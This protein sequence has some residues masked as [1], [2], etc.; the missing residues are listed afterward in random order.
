MDDIFIYQPDENNQDLAQLNN[1]DFIN[2]DNPNSGERLSAIFILIISLILIG[3]DFLSLYYS[4]QYIITSSKRYSFL[5]FERCIKY[6]SITEMYFTLFALLAAVSAALMALG[7]T[8][9]YDLFFEKFLVTFINFNYYV[10][11]L[12]LL[13]SSIVGLLNFNKVCYDCIGKNPNTHEFSLS[14]LI[15]L[16]FIAI[17]GGIITFIFSWLNSFEYVCDSIKF[18][19][20][21]NYFLGKVF[22]KYVLS[23][24]NER[25]NNNHERN[26]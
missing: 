17:I 25:Q 23:R 18:S 10:F 20:D 13:A 6:Q 7:I 22:W 11:G 19:K 24:N 16:I 3:M 26:E 14:T 8:I 2:D 21:G 9:G 12:F 5:V 15:C 4:Y 1:Q